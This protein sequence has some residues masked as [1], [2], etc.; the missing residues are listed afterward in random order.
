MKIKNSLKINRLIGWKHKRLLKNSS[1]S[2]SFCWKL[3][4]IQKRCWFYH[5]IKRE[6]YVIL[7]NFST[8]VF[9]NSQIP[10]F[11]WS[12]LIINWSQSKVWSSSS[13]SSFI[14]FLKPFLMIFLLHQGMC[15]GDKI[16]GYLSYVSCGFRLS[17]CKRKAIHDR[18]FFEARFSN[19]R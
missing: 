13:S 19:R 4:P 8:A 10:M 12:I 9:T 7:F 5:K 2:S 3:V 18:W 17:L 16:N 11:Y 6:P 14:S 1:S 15:H